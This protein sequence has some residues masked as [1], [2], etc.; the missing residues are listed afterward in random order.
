MKQIIWKEVKRQIIKSNVLLF[1]L[2]YAE[3]CNELARTIAASLR[4]CN[5]ASFKE[6]SQRWRS[7]R[8]QHCVQYNQPEK[9]RIQEVRTRDGK[10]AAYAA[11]RCCWCTAQRGN[12]N[13]HYLTASARRRVL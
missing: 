2:Y 8:W 13:L 5:A 10:S 6:M 1:Y 12:L 3:A 9:W 7:S 4:P 11:A